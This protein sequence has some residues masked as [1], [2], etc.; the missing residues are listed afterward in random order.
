MGGYLVSCYLVSFAAQREK[1]DSKTKSLQ[2]AL[3]TCF[4]SMNLPPS[5][6]QPQ[7]LLE[8]RRKLLCSYDV[9]LRLSTP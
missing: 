4:L 3:V 7:K 1:G 8:S 5:F 6:Y 9:P 2:D